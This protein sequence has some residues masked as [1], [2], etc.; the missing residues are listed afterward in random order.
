M[1]IKDVVWQSDELTQTYLTGVRGAIPL[2]QEQID[3]M[4]RLVQAACPTVTAVLDLGCGDGILGQA[5]LDHYPQ[6]KGV[7]VDLSEP[8]LEAARKRMDGSGRCTFVQLDY[9][10]NGWENNLPPS[11]PQYEVIVS[12]FSIHHQPDDRKKEI[13]A[14]LY[15]LLAPGGIFLNLEHVASHSPWVESRFEE[16]FVDSLFAYH[17]DIASDKTREQVD[18]EFYSRPDKAANLLAPVEN[19]CHWLRDIG[20]VHV[21][22]YLK[23]F[24]LALFGGIKANN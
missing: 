4:L 20:F 14:E 19:Q 16:F 1:E 15:N 10:E 3:V 7:F 5:V 6:T 23:V 18:R 8:M 9:G 13:Y 24:E 21:D 12:G 2:A 11:S 17:Q 22:C